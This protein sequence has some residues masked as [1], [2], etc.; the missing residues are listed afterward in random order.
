MLHKGQKAYNLEILQYC[1]GGAYGDVYYCRDIT[2]KCQALKI[3]SKIKLGTDWERELKGITNYRSASSKIPGVL[4]IYYVGED[5]ENLYYTMEP[6]DALPGKETYSPCTLTS[7]LAN[8]P[9]PVNELLPVL[10]SLLD[11]IAALHQAGYAHRDIK[12]DN[13]LFVSGRPK[14]GDLGLMSPISGSL[15]NL[16]GTMDFLPPELCLG[17]QAEETHQSKQR[18]DI[19]A[20]G[21]IIYCCLTGKTANQF[22]STTGDMKLSPV[23][24]RL[25]RLSLN[26]C[27]REPSLRLN[28]LQD[29]IKE[30][31]QLQRIYR[32]GETWKDKSVYLLNCSTSIFLQGFSW[33]RHHFLLFSCLVLALLVLYFKTRHFTLIFTLVISLALGTWQGIS[34]YL[35]SR[36]TAQ[37]TEPAMTFPVSS[38]TEQERKYTF[39]NGIYTLTVPT[40]WQL[41]D[42]D[43]IVASR[44]PGDILASRTHGLAI[45][46]SEGQSNLNSIVTMSILPLTADEARKLTDEELTVIIKANLVDDAEVISLRRY[47]NLHLGLDAIQFTG[48]S[49]SST[50]VICFI[51]P[52]RD[53][54]LAISG[55]IPESLF[56]K[57]NIEFLR[58][59]DSLIYRLPEK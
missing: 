21:K 16:A 12:P 10:Q 53:H 8:G 30:F 9:L 42:H 39:Y 20:F 38:K 55:I 37:N 11:S 51:Y 34:K 26:M 18:N 41:F 23:S 35:F 40:G 29:L 25:F 59:N 7:K 24:K 2:G 45:S 31:Q 19:Y 46:P 58:I 50:A 14:L 57:D 15:T 47:K 17:A 6:A 13:I 56:E 4:E 22:P 36:K 3:V 28:S 33:I 49:Q 44:L 43:A 54:S 48:L 27:D 32:T 52:Q 5:E 1:G